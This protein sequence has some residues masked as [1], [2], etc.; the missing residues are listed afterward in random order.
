MKQ[1]NTTKKTWQV[2]IYF[3]SGSSKADRV[4]KTYEGAYKRMIAL[5]EQNLYDATYRNGLLCDYRI[6]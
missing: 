1:G 5:Q 4:Y 6:G 2:F 3:P